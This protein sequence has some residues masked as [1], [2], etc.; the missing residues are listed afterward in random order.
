MFMALILRR[1]R[2][3]R[4]AVPPRFFLLAAPPNSMSTNG[5]TGSEIA[6]DPA[7]ALHLVQS[8]PAGSAA[9]QK[10]QERPLPLDQV[11]HAERRSESAH[12]W[13]SAH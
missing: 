12:P 10:L 1:A 8:E 13:V 4:S 2:N 7:C 9:R 3:P 6:Q 11:E 5:G